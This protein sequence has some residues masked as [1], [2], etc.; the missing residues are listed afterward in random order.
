[1]IPIVV[2]LA[3]P[4]ALLLYT[5]AEEIRRERA[6]RRRNRAWMAAREVSPRG[7]RARIVRATTTPTARSLIPGP[8]RGKGRAEQIAGQK[9]PSST[10]LSS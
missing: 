5:I 8:D 6:S 1:M 3:G 7:V 10:R 4:S 9:R 2:L